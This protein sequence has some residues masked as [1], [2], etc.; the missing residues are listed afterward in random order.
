MNTPR[1]NDN[2]CEERKLRD[3]IAELE[4]ANRTLANFGALLSH[5]LINALRSVVS[6]AELLREIPSVSTDQHTLSFLHTI[7]KSSRKLQTGIN[8]RLAPCNQ[9]SPNSIS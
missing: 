1:W 3:Q 5:D 8:E 4:I 9:P 6:F 7:L 2:S